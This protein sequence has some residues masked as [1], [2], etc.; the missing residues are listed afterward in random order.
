MLNPQANAPND[1]LADINYFAADGKVREVSTWK[2]RYLGVGDE[3]TR[4]MRVRDARPFADRFTLDA[5]GF[6]F[7]ELST[8]NRNTNDDA[9]IRGEYY[10]EVEEVVKNM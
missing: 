4:T 1:I 10:K 3:Y 9:V 7:V 6:Q 5:N 2:K 8:K